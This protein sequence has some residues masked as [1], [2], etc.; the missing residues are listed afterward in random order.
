MLNDD[1]VGWCAKAPPCLVARINFSSVTYMCRAQIPTDDDD[2][3]GGCGDGFH[4]QEQH[5]ITDQQ[6]LP[7]DKVCDPIMSWCSLYSSLIV[8][9]FLRP[10]EL[11]FTRMRSISYPGTRVPHHTSTSGAPSLTELSDPPGTG[12]YTIPYHA[13]PCPMIAM[14]TIVSRIAYHALSYHTIVNHIPTIPNH[15]YHQ[16]LASY[17][18]RLLWQ[19]MRPN[20][21][22]LWYQDS[23]HDHTTG[24]RW[25]MWNSK[26]KIQNMAS[27]SITLVGN[28][29]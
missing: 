13:I 21:D 7:F 2:E 8:I 16:T 9:V 27:N 1:R 18:T 3:D 25:N 12:S 22:T 26:W 28:N 23:P 17:P 15:T 29:I 4:Q 20:P 19:P 5:I 14:Y 10:C 11:N 24:E 6:T